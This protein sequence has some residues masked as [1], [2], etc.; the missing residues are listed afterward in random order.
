MQI[1]KSISQDY[2]MASLGK[3][4]WGSLFG[5]TATKKTTFVEA[6]VMNIAAMFQRYPPESFWG[7]DF[8]KTIHKINLSKWELFL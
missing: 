1:K 5:I 7:D 6:N 3:T 8:L 2:Y 4:I